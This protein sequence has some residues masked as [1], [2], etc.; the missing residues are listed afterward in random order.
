MQ[1]LLFLMKII[2]FTVKIYLAG[3]ELILCKFSLLSEL[4]YIVYEFIHLFAFVN[5]SEYSCPD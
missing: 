2:L 5:S 4:P 3:L 1:Y